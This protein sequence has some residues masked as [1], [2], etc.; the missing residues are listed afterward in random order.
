MTTNGLSPRARLVLRHI[1]TSKLQEVP[2]G[3]LIQF[4]PADGHV[5]AA[6]GE[7]RENLQAIEELICSR[8][9]TMWLIDRWPTDETEP[10]WPYPD[11]VL[12]P[13]EDAEGDPS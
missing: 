13:L 3:E 11:L 9:L 12:M 7:A 1:L 2:I 8:H 5:L 6:K 10:Q 4:S